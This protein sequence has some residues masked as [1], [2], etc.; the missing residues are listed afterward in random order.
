ME[1]KISLQEIDRIVY[2]WARYAGLRDSTKEGKHYSKGDIVELI[3]RLQRFK[4]DTTS[5][6]DGFEKEDETED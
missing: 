2:I 6:D 5:F 3:R 1:N 4:E